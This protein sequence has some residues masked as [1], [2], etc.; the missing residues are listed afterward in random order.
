M[1]GRSTLRQARSTAVVQKTPGR[2]GPS[3]RAGGRTGLAVV[4]PP[5]ACSKKINFARPGITKAM[6]MRQK[7]AAAKL[8]AAAAKEREAARRCPRR[9]PAPVG[10]DAREGRERSAGRRRAPPPS[11]P[12]PPLPVDGPALQTAIATGRIATH[13]GTGEPKR[14]QLPLALT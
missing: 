7:A 14:V 4:G 13:R 12:P 6:E 10:G 11:P 9:T 1:A 3:G 8:E 2:P 5:P